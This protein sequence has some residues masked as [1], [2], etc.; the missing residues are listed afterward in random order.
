MNTK[1]TGND[2]AGNGMAKGLTFFYGLGMLFII[3]LVLTIIN[4][5]FL[6]RVTQLWVKLL[7]LVPVLLPLLVFS[8]EYF[9][10][11]RPRP[12]SIAKQVHRMT[13]EIRSTEKLVN[14]RFSFRSSKG[15]SHSKLNYKRTE[16]HYHYYRNSNAV[17]Y[18]SARVFYILSDDFESPEHQLPIPYEPKITPF[19]NWESFYKTK[20]SSQDA[21]N[22]EF[23]YK[24]SKQ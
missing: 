2:A 9:E 14:P 17:F 16:D 19:T 5:F 6:N 3:A 12:P 8:I 20:S 22:L 13:I 21:I 7:F 11:G 23:R 24:I 18:E 15:G 1:F 4:A 10:I